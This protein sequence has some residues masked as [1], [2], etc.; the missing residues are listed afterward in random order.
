MGCFV[1]AL[2]HSIR[3]KRQISKFVPKDPYH[4]QPALNEAGEVLVENRWQH[5]DAEE[6]NAAFWNSLA[7]DRLREQ[8]F[9]RPN[10]NVAKN[11]IFFLGDGM[12][13]PTYAASRAYMGQ[14]QKLRGEESQL[15][16][17]KFP[18]TGLSKTYCVD[19][20]VADSACSAT[21]YLC[22]VKANYGTIGVTAKVRYNQCGIQADPANQVDSLAAWA[23]KAG[24]STGIVTTA[25]VTHASPSGAYAHVANREYECDA[26]VRTYGHNPAIC[27]DIAS[28]LVNNRTGTEFKV[29]LGGGRTKF[30]PNSMQDEQGNAGEREDGVNLI[31]EWKRKHSNGV[32][33][34]NRKGL[35]QTDYDRTQYLLGLFDPSHLQYNLDKTAQTDQPSLAEMTEAAIKMLQK[36]R[37]GYFVF[38]EG[39][40]IDHAHH[41]TKARKALDET[42]EFSKAID[43]AIQ[44]T[45]REDTLIIVT[46][47][48]AHC[49]SLAGYSF[50]GTDILGV[51]SEISPIDGLPYATLTYANGPGYRAEQNGRLDL[52]RQDMTNKDYEYPSLAPLPAETHGG[53]DVGIFALGPQAHLVSGVMEQNVIPHIV[54]YAACIGDGF[55]ICKKN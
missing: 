50:R 43:R 29:I 38:I 47:D 18:H 1:L 46:S 7:Q 15:A 48:H 52:R 28:Q 45:N 12:S 53:D 2:G 34:Y 17:D 19:R 14:Q 4:P 27:Q 44:L 8:V 55:T 49:M 11:V 31:D 41:E 24:K 30:L 5:V 20:Q 33:V 9:R 13:I 26:D 37:N 42:V 16:F 54:A 32:Y 36:D 3:E 40:R 6:E 10:L 25:R 22:G 23:Q 51:N 35:L 39:G 21:A